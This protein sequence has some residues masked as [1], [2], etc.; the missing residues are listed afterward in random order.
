MAM[1]LRVTA[2]VVLESPE[3]FEVARETWSVLSRTALRDSSIFI[4]YYEVAKETGSKFVLQ[5]NPMV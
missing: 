4:A 3:G 2:K 1:P 5:N